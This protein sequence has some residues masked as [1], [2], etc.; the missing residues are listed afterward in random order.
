M[1]TTPLTSTTSGREQLRSPTTGWFA[2]LFGLAGVLAAVWAGAALAARL[3]GARFTGRLADA[4]PGLLQLPSHLSDPALAW[5]P[6]AQASI[7]GPVIYWLSQLVVVV[8]G[9]AAVWV[10]WHYLAQRRGTTDG[11]GVE[12]SARFA[13]NSDLAVLKVRGPLPD[14]VVLGRS[15][16]GWR[17]SLLATERRTNICVIGTTGSGKTS[18]L[19]IPIILEMGEGHGSLVAATVKEDLYAHTHARR[20]LLGE[21]KVFDPL[22]IAV[23]R[24]NTWSPLRSCKTVSGA[25]TVARALTD[26]NRKGGIESDDFWHDSAFGL[27]WAVFFVAARQER[28]MADVVRWVTTHDHP[29]FDAKGR[30]VKPGELYPE[31]A[32]LL[33]GIWRATPADRPDSA[34]AGTPG[35]VSAAGVSI[36]Q[37]IIDRVDERLKR[38]YPDASDA[39]VIEALSEV[40]AQ[41]EADDAAAGGAGDDQDHHDQ[42]AG[43]AELPLD[44]G[45]GSDAGDDEPDD[46][47]GEGEAPT[48]PAVPDP[49]VV[50]ARDALWG[51]WS[52]E[53]RTRASIYTTCRSFIEPWSDPHVA[54]A[55]AGPCEITPEWLTD[56]DNTLYIIAPSR[57]QARLRAVFTALVTDLVDAAMEKAT[58]TKADGHG[59]LGGQLD[60]RLLLL[61]DEAANICP[62]RQLPEWSSTCGSHRISL[63]TVWQDRSQQRSRYGHEGAETIWNNS[64]AKIILSGVADQATSEVGR[65]LGE[66]EHERIGTSVDLSMG[67]RSLSTNTATRSLVTGD[68]LRRQARGRALLIYRDLPAIHLVLRPWYRDRALRALQSATPAVANT[69]RCRARL[70]RWRGS[71]PGQR[72]SPGRGA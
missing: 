58:R 24:S 67:R 18:E 2:A 53:E 32:R 5:P 62:V 16:C 54:A 30:L 52:N 40:I 56:A 34:A 23:Q 27:L 61:L 39:E 7:P 65:M 26:N 37:A 33:G 9:S 70:E 47:D 72:P 60:R 21:V 14:R 46:D 55:S 11:L 41:A 44:Y 57:D 38:G 8:A 45:P 19:C 49:E 63:L 25:Q 10:P 6:A 71:R 22:C 29:T 51:V 35:R 28:S 59:G 15:G 1:A 64:H 43:D 66:E 68:S 42:E 12:H 3:G 20:A 13:R 69:D 17:K 31:L 48:L 50:L 4:G 36:R